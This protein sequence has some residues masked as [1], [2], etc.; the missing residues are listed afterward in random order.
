[1]KAKG[2]HFPEMGR[3]L[4]NRGPEEDIYGIATENSVT[5]SVGNI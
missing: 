5:W 1:M 2:G 3:I 4:M